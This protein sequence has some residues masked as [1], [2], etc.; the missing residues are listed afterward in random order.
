MLMGVRNPAWLK[1]LAVASSSG[2]PY[3]NLRR[4]NESALEK[5]LESRRLR[6]E[7]AAASQAPRVK[8]VH[9]V[10]DGVQRVGVG[11]HRDA[12]GSVEGHQL[13][14][15]V[16]A[17]HEVT[18]DVALGGDHVDGRNVDRPAVP[19]HE[20]AAGPPGHGPAVLLGALLPDEVQD[21]LG[22]HPV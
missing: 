10:V 2:M 12:S 9:G 22:A 6:D 14:E 18:H 4:S 20:V 21:H 15:V 13:D 5:K 17:A 11:E 8:V 3:Q 1:A 19:D 16:V 7:N